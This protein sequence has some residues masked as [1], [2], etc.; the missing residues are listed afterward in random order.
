M[1]VFLRS[2]ALV[3]LTILVQPAWSEVCDVDADQDIDRLDIRLIAAARN[4]PAN[5]SEDSRDANGDGVITVADARACVRRC[6]LFRCEIITP[7]LIW[8]QGNWDEENWQ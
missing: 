7:G 8:D 5:G 3:C 6:N 4:Q 2:I 1:Q